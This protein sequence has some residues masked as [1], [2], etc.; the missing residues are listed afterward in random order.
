MAFWRHIDRDAL[1]QDGWE[2]TATY[3]W[4]IALHPLGELNALNYIT[5]A[6][7]DIEEMRARNSGLSL[8][9]LCNVIC[10]YLFMRN[11]L[12]AVSML[13]KRPKMLAGWCCV[14][15]TIAGL[16]YS[17]SSLAVYLP[18]GPSCR[19]ALWLVG[20]GSSI[21]VLCVGTALLQKAYLVHHHNK[22]LLGFGITLLLPQ[23]IFTYIV[24]TSPVVMT[25]WG[26]CLSCYPTYLPW[27]KLAMDMPINLVFSISFLVVVYQQ[28]RQFGSAA[29]KRLIRNGIQT[30]CFIV[31]SNM[32]CMLCVAFEVFGMFSEFFFIFDWVIT[33]I[34]LVHHCTAMRFSTSEPHK[35]HTRN[36]L[37]ELDSIKTAAT[38]FAGKSTAMELGS[39]HY[40]AYANY[41][42]MHWS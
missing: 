14:L 8:Q 17:I 13:Y 10:T 12:L 21:S 9:T 4:G 27:A 6:Q 1:L 31:L 42:T 2:K 24:W 11:L 33:S 18:D 30:M 22:W 38:A 41:R 40:E 39:G 32:I 29:W 16:V 25:P 26:G 3:Q 35:P 7:G 15:Q 28:Y 5:K 34:L 36:I 23:P 20:V 19:I 37:H